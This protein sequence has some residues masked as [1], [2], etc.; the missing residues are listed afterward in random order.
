MQTL[1]SNFFP[2][3]CVPLLFFFLPHVVG[4]IFLPF[5]LLFLFLRQTLL[6]CFSV[7]VSR[8]AACSSFVYLYIDWGLLFFFGGRLCL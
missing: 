6:Q 1:V 8:C 3:S 5:V 2:Y 4:I 7:E